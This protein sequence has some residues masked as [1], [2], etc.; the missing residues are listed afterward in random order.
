MRRTT[1]S[2]AVASS[3][4]RAPAVKAGADVGEGRQ[5]EGLDALH[6]GEEVDGYSQRGRGRVDLVF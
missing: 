3:P 2:T 5:R 6:K 4:S 1:S